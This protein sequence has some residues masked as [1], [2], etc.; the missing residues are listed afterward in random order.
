MDQ[1]NKKKRANQ[2]NTISTNRQKINLPGFSRA[3]LREFS[4]RRAQLCVRLK[5]E[6]FNYIP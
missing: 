3:F 4:A 6:G 2:F 5:G 1:R